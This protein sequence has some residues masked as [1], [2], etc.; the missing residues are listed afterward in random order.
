MDYS[1]KELPEDERPRERLLKKGA[2][3]LTDSELVAILIGGGTREMNARELASEIISD[4][5]A[6]SFPSRKYEDFERFPGISKA[7]GSRLV[8]AG[9]LA[10]RMKRIERDKIESL[11]DIRSETSDMKLLEKEV[12]RVFY[13][14]SGNE[15]LGRRD[16]QGAVSSVGLPDREILSEALRK[17]SSALVI[18]HNHPSGKSESTE[19]DRRATRDLMDSCRS[20]EIDLLDHVIVG[21]DL[22]SMRANSEGGF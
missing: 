19:A 17:N 7:R 2:G 5:P 16:F 9:E 18:A 13:I 15:V 1:I 12:L 8:A 10:R 21:E 22:H 3:S 11:Q 20:L 6:S 4:I 14:S